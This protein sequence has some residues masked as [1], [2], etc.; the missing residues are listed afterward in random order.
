MSRLPAKLEKL[1]P[2]LFSD[3]EATKV[4]ISKL[5]QQYIKNFP[6]YTD[7][8][9]EHTL[10][11]LNLAGEI[12]TEEEI[13]S[14][15]SDELY[16]LCTASILHDA[17]MCI[18]EEKIKEISN[19]DE[20]I[21]YRKD[22]LDFSTE[23]YIRDIHH[24]LS[25]KF[26]IEEW[27]KLHIPSAKY[28]EAI[29]LVARGHR[30]VDLN[31]FELYK[32]QFFVKNGREFVCLPYL[33]CILRIADELDISNLRTPD[34]LYK[35]YIPD[36]DVSR[37]E[38]QKHK[39]TTQINFMDDKV[40]IEVKCTDHNILG[41]LDEQFDKVTSVLIQCQ[42]TIRSIHVIENRRFELKL[43]TLEPIYNYID[44]DPKGIKYSFDVKNVINA[45][46]GEDLYKNKEAALREVVQNAVDAC[47]YKRTLS[48]NDYKPNIKIVIGEDFI[49]VEDNG[50]GM[51]EFI[52]ENYFGKLASSF[53]QQEIVQSD[54]QAIG[55]FG[56]GVFSFFLIS[57][58]IDVETKRAE[59]PGLKFRTDKDPNAYF[60]FFEDFKKENTGTKITLHLKSKYHTKFNVNTVSK[61]V[62]NT[63]RF[64]EIPISVEDENEKLNLTSDKM[65]IDFDKD[66]L[67]HFYYNQRETASMFETLTYSLS[68]SELEGIVGIL[69]PKNFKEIPSVNLYQLIDVNSFDDKA[70][71]GAD[72]GSIAFSQKGVLINNYESNVGFTFGKINI[73]KKLKINLSR[74]EFVNQ[75]SVNNSLAAFE[76]N[77]VKQ[78]FDKF[79]IHHSSN[80]IEHV[81][82]TR[83][84]IYNY[85][86]SEEFKDKSEMANLVKD[87]FCY[88]F[89]I[90]SKTY[91]YTLNQIEENF[92]EFV[93][94]E[95]VNDAELH[96]KYLNIPSLTKSESSRYRN[97][98]DQFFNSFCKFGNSLTKIE[99]RY[100]LSYSK[101]AYNKL[102]ELKNSLDPYNLYYNFSEFDSKKIGI[103]YMEGHPS[104]KDK[105]FS[106][107][108][109]AHF[110]SRHP[111]I[112]KIAAFVNEKKL[113][114]KEV[115][116]L[117][118]LLN[119]I[120]SLLDQYCTE[121]RVDKTIAK[122]NK[123]IDN[124]LEEGRLKL[125]YLTKEDFA[126]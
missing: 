43:K 22:N 39:A 79:F 114:S 23:R 45:F 115:R 100:F 96:S 9:I 98:I 21:Q 62:E 46:I 91:Y 30:K 42:K 112:L 41:A 38:W 106:Y 60:H 18:P 57:E 40:L 10:E 19:T 70:N 20:L 105:K 90:K 14:L 27:N 28:A 75:D 58:F 99:E 111:M 47:N 5:L 66:I 11:V 122:S 97:D 56:I 80:S 24:E 73:I 72:H 113:N 86:P 29:G 53:Y 17:G 50:Q 117:K 118:E 61:F 92:K 125:D 37:K 94:F 87:C 120:E 51:D 69:V 84:F 35:Y 89:L 33:S 85:W 7:H 76:V 103:N 102:F 78:V 71:Y 2:K 95:D 81:K 63:F 74:T 34:I 88:E 36:N 101:S 4:I 93:I 3:F 121:E 15:N 119:I 32:P 126:V 13:N 77:L 104:F 25:Y 54:F 59:K 109:E 8:S 110:N 16:I 55:Q 52:I 65:I 116:L 107:H 49:S 12:M 108:G 82:L 67:P 31:D 48:K 44:F 83:W 6:T 123:I 26:I 1:N 64:T 68:N 124:I